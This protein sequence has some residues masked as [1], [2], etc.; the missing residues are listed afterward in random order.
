MPSR[1]D[2]LLEM[3]AASLDESFGV[4]A[5]Y[6]QRGRA[7]TA[8]FNVTYLDIEEMAESQDSTSTLVKSRH[9]YPKASD[10]AVGGVQLTPREGDVIRLVETGERFEV[11]RD[12]A[13]PGVEEQAGGLRWLLRA[14]KV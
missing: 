10:L 3:G 9:F 2:Q 5:T 13:L 6:Q 4:A 14:K 7:A 12:A 11:L 1:L 8:A